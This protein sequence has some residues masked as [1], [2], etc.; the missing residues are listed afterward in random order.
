MWRVCLCGVLVGSVIGAM[1]APHLERDRSSTQQTR[2]QDIVPIQY[3]TMSVKAIRLELVGNRV[4]S[5]GVVVDTTRFVLTSEQGRQHAEAVQQMRPSDFYSTLPFLTAGCSIQALIWDRLTT[6]LE[7]S[8]D[9]D[10]TAQSS[11][12]VGDTYVSRAT[13]ESLNYGY[14]DGGDLVRFAKVGD[15]R[16][17]KDRVEVEFRLGVKPNM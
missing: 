1:I 12:E 15:A 6:T 3:G 14:R 7:A 8:G 2:Q 13:Y 9:L 17:I 5:G 11:L 10:G 16:I 4:V